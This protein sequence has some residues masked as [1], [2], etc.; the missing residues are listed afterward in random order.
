MA[1]FIANI[2]VESDGLTALVE[3]LNYSAEGLARTWPNRYAVDPGAKAPVP[4]AKA[5]AIARNPTK[6]A[7]ATYADRMGNGPE[8]SGDGWKYRGRG[9][10]QITGKSNYAALSRSIGIDLV[11]NPDRLCEPEVAAISAAWFFAANG[12]IDLAE[13]HSFDSV[14]RVINGKA[15]SKSNHGPLRT[16]RYLA[17]AKAMGG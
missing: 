2:G 5:L 12:C 8:S 7:N 6:I 3:N 11:A 9:L 16:S 13:R 15:P 14:V 17:C 10:M 1:A 4:N